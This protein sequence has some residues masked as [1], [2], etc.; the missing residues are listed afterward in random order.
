M[1]PQVLQT[2]PCL[3]EPPS[4]LRGTVSDFMLKLRGICPALVPS[5]VSPLPISGTIVSIGTDNSNGG[6]Q[7][8]MRQLHILGANVISSLKVE[9]HW[10]EE[11]SFGEVTQ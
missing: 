5:A 8:I 1:D 9:R 6:C 2:L 7:K 4:L 11:F 10:R 3:S